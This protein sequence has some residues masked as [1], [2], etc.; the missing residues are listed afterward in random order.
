MPENEIMAELRAAREA[1]A[2]RFNYDL[3]AIFQDLQ[4]KQE[5]RSDREIV[6]ANPQRISELEASHPQLSRSIRR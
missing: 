6:P 1:Y 2:K 5:Q 3:E 4:E